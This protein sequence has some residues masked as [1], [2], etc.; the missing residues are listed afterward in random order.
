MRSHQRSGGTTAKS[1]CV[2]HVPSPR[3]RG[4]IFRPWRSRGSCCSAGFAGVAFSR[5]RLSR[6]G[7]LPV[8][9]ETAIVFARGGLGRPERDTVEQVWWTH[10]GTAAAR[11]LMR[12]RS[13]GDTPVVIYLQAT[14]QH[15]DA[16]HLHYDGYCSS[17]STG[18]A[19]YR[20]SVGR[21]GAERE[22]VTPPPLVEY[23]RQQCARR[24]ARIV[25][26]D[27]RWIA[28]L[29]ILLA[30]DEA[31]FIL[32][33][34]A[35]LV[36]SPTPF[37]TSRSGCSP[38]RSNY[39]ADRRVR[40]PV[41]FLHSPRTD[42]SHRGR[43][44]LVRRRAASQ[45]WWSLRRPRVCGRAGPRSSRP[46]DVP[47]SHRSCVT[48]PS[49]QP[50][51]DDVSRLGDMRRTLR[52]REGS[53]LLTVS[54]ARLARR[55]QRNSP[56]LPSSATLRALPSRWRSPWRRVFALPH[57]RHIAEQHHRVRRRRDS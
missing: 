12:P 52:A 13:I 2:L 27:C 53:L 21:G 29:W 28:V 19:R 33:L 38:T 47:A 30:R 10:D 43:P 49:A 26:Y 15:R 14:T 56:R 22:G 17:G 45:A 3:R 11:W 20:G 4:T 6:R 5:R 34:P 57:A 48:P 25:I 35:S 31:A 7:R 41:L 36:P 1:V 9:Q 16:I 39:L 32:E 42:Y 46:S 18:R 8:T 55:G 44:P 37:R 23:L 50:L 51:R 40:P 24:S 54:G